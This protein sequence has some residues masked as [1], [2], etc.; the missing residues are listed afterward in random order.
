MR[1]EHIYPHR[2]VRN[3]A[4]SQ[5]RISIALGF[6]F[7]LNFATAYFGS[8]LL[9]I[10]SQ[11]SKSILTFIDIP[12]KGSRIVEIFSFLSPLA[13]PNIPFPHPQAFPLRTSLLFILSILVLILIHRSIP[14]SRNFVVFLI[15]LLCTAR[16]V[17]FINPSF[18]LGSA[19]YE[20]MWIR[21]ELLV[22]LILPWV[23]AF[24]FILTL[25]SLAG[26][27]GWALMLQIYAVIWS[28]VRLAFC[29]AVLHFTGILF[30]PLIWFCLGI[31]FDLVYVLVFYSLALHGSMKKVIGERA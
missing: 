16:A 12:I 31:L 17:I 22:W 30:L 5:A 9:T 8:F 1:R 10:H 18:Y 28:A 15:V 6:A 20:Q 7:L 3:F 4:I 24:L 23:S 19:T 26:A 29:L 13:V 21:G 11:I 27:V 2:S 25:P 14:L